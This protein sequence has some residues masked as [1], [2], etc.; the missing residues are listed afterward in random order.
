MDIN[1][2]N[3][4]HELDEPDIVCRKLKTL[5]LNSAKSNNINLVIQ[6]F[7]IHKYPCKKAYCISGTVNGNN[8]MITDKKDTYVNVYNDLYNQLIHKY[9][10]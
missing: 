10:L 1:I 5:F 8:F 6:D 4:I 2:N 3:I 9:V 7:V